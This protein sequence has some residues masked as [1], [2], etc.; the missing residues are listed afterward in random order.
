LKFVLKHTNPYLFAAHVGTQMKLSSHGFIGFAAMTAK[1]IRE[2]L[3]IA[4][5]YVPLVI[6]GVQFRLETSEETAYFFVDDNINLHPLREMMIIAL[7]YGLLTMGEVISGKKL[8]GNADVDFAAPEENKN[9]EDYLPAIIRFNQPFNR[10]CFSASYLDL[11]LVMADPIA[12]QLAREQCERELAALGRDHSFLQRARN[13]LY[14]EKKGFLSAEQL[15]HELHVSSRTLK[16]QLA[17]QN[18][19]YSELL[20]DARCKKAVLMLEQQHLSIEE[21]AE[22][23]GYSDVANF[24]RAFKRWTGRSPNAYRKSR[25]SAVSN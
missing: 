1:N 11:P 14:S 18:T 5:R 4:I 12:M 19:T 8:F 13:A 25:T 23:L 3:D 16:R 21:I 22:K 15:A 2:A 6:Q 10:V 9:Y 20:E 7:G 24:S 17:L